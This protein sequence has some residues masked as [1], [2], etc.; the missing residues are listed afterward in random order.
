[1]RELTF[2]DALNE[3][4]DEE[5]GRDPDTFL[6]GEE[7]GAYNG[8]YKVSKGLLDKYGPKR[9]VDSPISELG[10]CGLG[11]GAAMMG[12]KPIIEVMTWNF[13]ILAMDQIVNTA[14]KMRYMAAGEL[15]C[16]IVFRG[17]NGA[18]RSLGAQHSQW[19]EAQ[20]AYFP[21]IKVIVPSTPADA[22]G[23]LK[24]A[25]RDPDPVVFMESETMYAW[26]G[27]VPEGEY[28]I[29][30]GKGDIKREGTDC[31]IVAWGKALKIALDGAEL[32]AKDGINCEVVDP[33]TIRPLDEEIIVNSVR[34]TGACVVFEEGW[35]YYNV[36]AQISDIVQR[37]C[38]D[39]LDSPVIRVT[40]ADVPMPYARTLEDAA[41]PD[42]TSVVAGV[43]NA[44]NVRS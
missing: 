9:V 27:M 21:G 22:K 12:L 33:R 44:L 38:F 43:K 11:V 42:P 16:P 17:P 31:T 24:S 14:A 26:K 28:T 3:A 37:A 15:S 13:A 18:A 1:M 25:I 40:G 23:L 10:F 5:L 34:K 4:L 41:R 30:I 8:A 6:M 20:Y 19:F 2:R 35:P 32:L 36:G 39:V 29:P 7:V